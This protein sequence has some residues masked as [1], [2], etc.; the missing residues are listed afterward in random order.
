[1]DALRTLLLLPIAGALWSVGIA[2][3][4]PPV[5][6]DLLASG[7]PVVGSEVPGDRGSNLVVGRGACSLFDT[8]PTAVLA[9]PVSGWLVRARVR[10]GVVVD[11]A[12]ADTGVA[13]EL[14]SIPFD[15]EPS[16]DEEIGS[17]GVTRVVL[18]KDRIHL[19]VTVTLTRVLHGAA[20]LV[21]TGRFALP[22][23][24]KSSAP[25]ARA[26]AGCMV[27]AAVGPCRD[28]CKAGVGVACVRWAALLEGAGDELASRAA[29]RDGCK[30]G[31]PTA[32]AGDA[33]RR[34]D[35]AGD[36]AAALRLLLDA[37]RARSAAACYW[38]ENTGM[39]AYF[40]GDALEREACGH[41]RAASRKRRAGARKPGPV[42]LFPDTRGPPAKEPADYPDPSVGWSPDSQEFGYWYEDPLA[43]KEGTFRAGFRAR[44][45][46]LT[47]RR[48]AA[49]PSKVAWRFG[50][51]IELVQLSRDAGADGISRL[52]W[53]LGVRVAKHNAVL[54][55]PSL[56]IEAEE[57]AGVLEVQVA[58]VSP[59]GRSI[60]VLLRRHHGV[61]NSWSFV[62]LVYDG[63]RLAAR[64]FNKAG[65]HHHRKK[66]FERAVQLFER[67]DE[68]DP[69][70]AHPSYNRAC[71][72][73]R[74]R[75]PLARE[76]LDA[77]IT[78]HGDAIRVK[79]RSDPDFSGVREEPWFQ[80]LTRPPAR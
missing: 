32:C 51:E 59:D 40:D 38:L 7:E 1:M 10:G 75:S 60:G 31:H 14:G 24:A 77:A 62:P 50:R 4:A 27:G 11:L 63:D 43:E 20:P 69:T 26:A 76:A 30:L 39:G 49:A 8:H 28:A 58:Q 15:F 54:L 52:T 3:A 46:R 9:S 16:D 42:R 17:P 23:Q 57:D 55:E 79:A 36:T 64:A 2:S 66:R 12:E 18:E 68:A 72:L 22:K 35:D 21:L 73:A 56:T 71:A 5:P 53:R 34:H 48:R 80:R 74:L 41:G 13:H 70:Y 6:P 61:I 78:R 25:S 29:L 19:A 44:D 37:C 65:L 33:E 45:G 47:E 67:A